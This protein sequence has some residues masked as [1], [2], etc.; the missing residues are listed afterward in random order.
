MMVAALVCALLAGNGD[1]AHAT[2]FEEGF[3][4]YADGS[5]PPTWTNL[6]DGSSG[7]VTTEQAHSGSKSFRSVSYYN[8]AR[9]DCIALAIPNRFFYGAA[10]YLTEADRG[11]AVGFGFVQPGTS[12]TGRIANA[13]LFANDGNVYFSTR[14]VASTVVGTWV[15]D[16]WIRFEV[17]VD[18]SGDWAS[19]TI[20]G[21]GT[22]GIPDIDPKTL[23]ASLYGVEVPL[24][25]F[26]MF[27]QNFTGG[28]SGVVYYDD[29]YLYEEVAV[30]PT[31]WSRIKAL[32]RE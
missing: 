31:S 30:E 17:F 26:G 7:M 27:G 6:F 3:E 24:D 25:Q 19:V 16:Q 9:W 5:Y 22:T 4:S 23:P 21:G 15:P 20:F 1:R 18:Y 11:G 29:L 14:T 12:S 8:W 32:Y 2:S 13:V 28:V 10:I